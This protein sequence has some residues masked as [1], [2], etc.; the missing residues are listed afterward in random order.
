MATH[1]LGSLS[2]RPAIAD[3]R[4]RR[5]APS[6]PED[7]PAGRLGGG[8]GVLARCRSCPSVITTKRQQRPG[9]VIWWNGAWSDGWR[10]RPW[11]A[12]SS[13][14]PGTVSRGMPSTTASR[15]SVRVREAPCGRGLDRAARRGSESATGRA[16]WPI[17]TARPWT[18]RPRSAAWRRALGWRIGHGPSCLPQA[19]QPSTWTW[20]WRRSGTGEPSRSRR[21]VIPPGLMSSAGSPTPRIEREEWPIPRTCS[22]RRSRG[23]GRSGTSSAKGTRWFG[24]PRACGPRASR[25]ELPQA[26]LREAVALLERETPGPELVRGYAAF[27]FQKAVTEPTD[28]AI[29]WADKTLML[30]ERFGLAEERVAG[31]VYRGLSRCF[32]G[33]SGGVGN[34]RTAVE[35]GEGRGIVV[36]RLGP[37]Q[38]GLRPVA[39]RRVGGR[40]RLLPEGLETARRRRFRNE[41]MANARCDWSGP[42][43]SS[44]GGAKRSGS[45]VA[46]RPGSRNTVRTT[47]APRWSTG[48]R[49]CCFTEV[50]PPPPKESSNAAWRPR[51]MPGSIA[52]RQLAGDLS[53]GGATEAGQAAG[54]SFGSSGRHRRSRAARLRIERSSCPT[55]SGSRWPPKTSDWPGDC[56]RTPS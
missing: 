34:L 3:R 41:E 7:A 54:P 47:T 46:S 36:C 42:C 8:T 33:D 37:V 25:R 40:P 32:L 6:A 35:S 16:G 44:D 56:S 49:R 48:S 23:T 9:S 31:L 27:A 19:T 26:M 45:V 39:E 14:P 50:R 52:H 55:S 51:A 18:W 24:S 2:Q 21:R 38:P 13:T 28:E 17:T 30:A 12:R 10:P 29:A 20:P 43:T 22:R 4:A 5:R 15:R 1:G 11:R 53:P